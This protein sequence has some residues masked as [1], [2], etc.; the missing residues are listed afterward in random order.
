MHFPSDIIVGTVVGAAV[1][2]LIPHLRKITKK[3]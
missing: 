1:G 3:K 2:I